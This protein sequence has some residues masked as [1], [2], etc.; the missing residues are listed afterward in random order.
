MTTLSP[1]PCISFKTFLAFS[2][3]FKPRITNQVPRD[4]LRRFNGSNQRRIIGALKFFGFTVGE[5][6]VTEKF[7]HFLSVLDTSEA[8]Q[9]FRDLLACYAD[10]E[11]VTGDPWRPQ[12][13]HEWFLAR[14]G[15]SDDCEAAE[16]LFSH[17]CD[18]SES[19]ELVGL[20]LAIRRF[21]RLPKKEFRSHGQDDNLE[22]RS[23]EAPLLRAQAM[24]NH[25]CRCGF[26]DS[27]LARFPEFDP[28]W[29]ED[30][31]AA[32]TKAY[33]EVLN[34]L[35]MGAWVSRT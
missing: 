33:L 17:L 18:A 27:V 2:R 15:N 7:R 29:T 1:P 28:S 19:E 20:G 9:G 21:H 22:S 34:G 30:R 26:L 32:W 13:I 3:E 16:A 14:I 31:R 12:G 23:D 25:E 5:D 10:I 35:P 4:S 6:Q 11:I 24:G 8:C